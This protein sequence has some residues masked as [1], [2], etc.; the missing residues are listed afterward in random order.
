MQ[1]SD[2]IKTLRSLSS[3]PWDSPP[4]ISV[5]IFSYDDRSVCPLTGLTNSVNVD[6]FVPFLSQNTLR[7]KFFMLSWS[8]PYIE[9]Q[10]KIMTSCLSWALIFEFYFVYHL[11]DRKWTKYISSCELKAPWSWVFPV[12]NAFLVTSFYRSFRKVLFF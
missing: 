3:R 11:S 9:T 2:L 1:L 8:D 7:P 10:Y 4:L 5:M 12:S 6:I